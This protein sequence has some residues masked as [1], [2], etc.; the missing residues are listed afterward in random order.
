[1]G[2]RLAGVGFVGFRWER[3]ELEFGLGFFEGRE[4]SG[5]EFRGFSMGEMLA[6]V[7]FVYV[8]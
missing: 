8:S 1:M 4:V 2:E 7:H 5:S 3:Y 6:V